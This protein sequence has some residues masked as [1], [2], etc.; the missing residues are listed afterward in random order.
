[1]G[2]RVE[3]LR[4]LVRRHQ[5]ETGS[6]V[7]EALLADWP[8]SLARFTEVMPRDYKRVM[9]AKAKAVEDGLDDEQAEARIMEVLHG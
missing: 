9:D 4:G 5:E 2:D 3:E 8:A 6:A 1:M 7:A